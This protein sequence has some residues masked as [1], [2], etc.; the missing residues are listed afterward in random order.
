M[1]GN[2]PQQEQTVEI[3]MNSNEDMQIERAERLASLDTLPIEVN[4]EL[5]VCPSHVNIITYFGFFS[6][7]VIPYDLRPH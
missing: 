3:S 4:K 7:L 2:F 1:F 5:C 6:R